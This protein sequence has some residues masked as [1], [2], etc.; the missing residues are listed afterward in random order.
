MEA[1]HSRRSRP[2]ESRILALGGDMEPGWPGC[3]VAHVGSLC[4]RGHYLTLFCLK[5]DSTI[6]AL[7]LRSVI[8]RRNLETT[9][10]GPDSFPSEVPEYGQRIEKKIHRR[11]YPGARP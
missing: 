8:P 4:E 9:Q 3:R 11:V 7:R 5:R 6:R 2:S 1:D 10:P